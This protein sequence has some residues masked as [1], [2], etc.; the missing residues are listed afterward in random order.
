MSTQPCPSFLPT[1]RVFAGRNICRLLWFCGGDLDS[2][3]ETD[4]GTDGLQLISV[5][6]ISVWSSFWTVCR[7]SGVGADG[8][9]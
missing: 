7:V 4:A 1:S 5:H 9:V 8:G 6:V 3:D 2:S